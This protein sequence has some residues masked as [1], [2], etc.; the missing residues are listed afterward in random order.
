MTDEKDFQHD[1][2]VRR[3]S[4]PYPKDENGKPLCRW[5][6]GPL[7]GRRTSWC[8]D[9]CVTEYKDRYDS[10]HQRRQVSKRDRGRCSSCSL[11]TKAF[12]EELKQAYF[13]AMRERDVTPNWQDEYYIHTSILEK[14]PSCMALLE[15]HGF[16]LKD[17]SFGGHGMSDFWD[18]DHILPVVHGGGGTGLENLR[19]LCKAC[20]RRETK[21][22]AASRAAARKKKT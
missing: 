17:V 18:M 8:S 14:T 6:R 2:T 13:K 22:L 15:K 1:R 12:R 7:S 11:D 3:I 20:H 9:K 10:A 5:C 21:A 19:T 4:L 16:T